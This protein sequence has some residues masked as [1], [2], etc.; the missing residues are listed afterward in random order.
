LN[1]QQTEKRTTMESDFKS[2]TPKHVFG[3]IC[4]LFDSTRL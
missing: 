4:R 3:I 2:W 1:E